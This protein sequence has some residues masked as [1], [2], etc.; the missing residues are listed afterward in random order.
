MLTVKFTGRYTRFDF[1]ENT[2][3]LFAGKTLLHAGH[4]VAHEEIT[5][6]RMG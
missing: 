1:T 6:V 5:N 3:E 4:H 2:D